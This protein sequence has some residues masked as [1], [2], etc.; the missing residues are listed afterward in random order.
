MIGTRFCTK[1]DLGTKQSAIR[2][3]ILAGAIALSFV[4]Q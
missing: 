1:P 2:S 3:G 4:M